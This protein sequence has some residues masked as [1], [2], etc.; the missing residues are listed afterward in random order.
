MDLGNLIFIG[1]VIAQ[2]V[3]GMNQIK[4]NVLVLGIVILGMAYTIAYL[5]MKGIKLR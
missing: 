5:I 4:I 2:F 1:L 3:P